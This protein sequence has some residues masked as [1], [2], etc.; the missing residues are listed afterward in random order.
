MRKRRTF[1]RIIGTL[2]II[3]ILFSYIPAISMDGCPEEDHSVNKK[4]DCGYVFHCPAVYN[5]AIPQ[6]SI[7]S[8]HGELKCVVILRKT[9]EFRRLI[10]HPPERIFS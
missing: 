7:L 2:V 1:L 8:L 3:A 9:D 10:F 6:L 4:M 5:P